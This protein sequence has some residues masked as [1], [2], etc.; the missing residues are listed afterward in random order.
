MRAY[1][2]PS[3]PL[4]VKRDPIATSMGT[5]YWRGYLVRFQIGNTVSFAFLEEAD[6][7]D[8][9]IPER[10]LRLAKALLK[11][12]PD[13]VLLSYQVEICPIRKVAE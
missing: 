6:V 11:T 1:E 13:G 8:E 3:A 7:R 4:P 5:L 2:K 12:V 10:K 9:T